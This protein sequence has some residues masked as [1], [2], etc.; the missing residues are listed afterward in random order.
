METS[1]KS[2]ALQILSTAS[3]GIA[4]DLHPHT[5]QQSFLLRN[6]KRV[7]KECTV[8]LR[9]S[10]NRPHKAQSLDLGHSQP[11]RLVCSRFAWDY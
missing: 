6:L 8:Y 9:C 5:P 4:S 10:R 11:L 3:S 2:R 7:I 1:Y